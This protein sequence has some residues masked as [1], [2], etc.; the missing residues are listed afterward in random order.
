MNNPSSTPTAL[1]PSITTRSGLS[2]SVVA[3]RLVQ[4][5]PAARAASRP[6]TAAG[7]PPTRLRR[8]DARPSGRDRR[9]RQF[10]GPDHA[11]PGRP[12]K[13]PGARQ[14]LQGPGR[15]DPPRPAEV[16]AARGTH[17]QRVR[18]HV[19]LRRAASVPTSP[20]SPTAATSPSDARAASPTTAS[21][22]P[23]SP[24]SS[25]SAEPSARTTPRLSPRAC[26]S[27]PEL[28]RRHLH[29]RSCRPHRAGPHAWGQCHGVDHGPDPIAS[30][31]MLADLAGGKLNGPHSAGQHPKVAPPHLDGRSVLVVEPPPGTSA[32]SRLSR[33]L[34]PVSADADHAF[35]VRPT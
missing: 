21:L 6:S 14:V 2:L 1:P 22:T 11:G 8:R 15:P 3:S 9:P 34:S 19:G 20:I 4:T 10:P 5:L 18:E 27:T 33:S 35:R 25:C 30:W 16:P 26:A 28:S 29:P 17:R 13:P 31:G 7:T 24:T 32:P 12:G 23:G